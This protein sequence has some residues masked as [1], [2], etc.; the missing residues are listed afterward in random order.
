M[1]RK[2]VHKGGDVWHFTVEDEVCSLCRKGTPTVIVHT[3][4]MRRTHLVRWNSGKIGT[5]E[6][7]SESY[8]LCAQ[9]RRQVKRHDSKGKLKFTLWQVD[10]PVRPEVT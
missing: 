1:A 9:C 6:R 3:P 8:L 5:V 10:N 2:L 4:Q 7:H